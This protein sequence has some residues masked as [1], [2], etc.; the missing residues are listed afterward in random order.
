M[1]SILLSLF[2][3]VFLAG[4][5]NACVP[6]HQQCLNQTHYQMCAHGTW[7][8]AQ[9]IL[10]RC[11]QNGNTVYPGHIEGPG[12]NDQHQPVRNDQYQPGHNNQ[13]SQ[14]A[15]KTCSAS[16][17]VN[18]CLDRSRDIV[19]T[20]CNPHEKTDQA[21]YY[22]CLCHNAREV[23]VCYNNCPNMVAEIAAQQ[24]HVSNFCGKA[25]TY[26]VANPP[27]V[28]SGASATTD[29]AK[30][31]SGG[32]KVEASSNGEAAKNDKVSGAQTAVASITLLSM[33]VGTALYL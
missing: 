27:A 29:N 9:L 30:Q 7:Q 1:K 20:H 8:V 25:S 15:P 23:A 17:I 16:H 26:Q 5:T 28:Y 14:S 33:L 12:R 11:V 22:Q 31:K 32:S 18:A 19:A 2:A 10:P 6:G 21:R 3:V 24:G 13:P 4:L